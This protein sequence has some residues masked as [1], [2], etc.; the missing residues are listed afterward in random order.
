MPGRHLLLQLRFGSLHDAGPYALQDVVGGHDLRLEDRVPRFDTR[1]ERSVDAGVE[2]AKLAW[3]RLDL[4]RGVRRVA[5]AEGSRHCD[6]RVEPV[7]RKIH[8][9]FEVDSDRCPVEACA[10]QYRRE[11]LT[12]SA[13]EA[14]SRFSRV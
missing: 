4:E 7:I 1:G 6:R 13:L 9:T 11:V 2:L 3:Q 8:A 14:V 12:R 5:Q 10:G